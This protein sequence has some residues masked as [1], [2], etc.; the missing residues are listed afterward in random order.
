MKAVVSKKF[1]NHLESMT[2]E[3][4]TEVLGGAEELTGQPAAVRE[5]TKSYLKPELKCLGVLAS[6]AGSPAPPTPGAFWDP[7]P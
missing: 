3:Q 5:V 4:L 1:K 6:V 7:L 2:Q